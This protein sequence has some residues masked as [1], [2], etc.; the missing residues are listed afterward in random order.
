MAGSE[1]SIAVGRLPPQLGYLSL[2]EAML[3]T[4]RPINIGFSDV[5]GA[6]V[7]KRRGALRHSPPL[8]LNKGES[9][10]NLCNIRA[11]TRT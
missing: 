6:Q 7:H 11:G 4:N 1:T 10:E 8:Q 5:S 9:Y 3:P 2:G